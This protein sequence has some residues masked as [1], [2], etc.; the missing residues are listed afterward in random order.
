MKPSKL[1]AELSNIMETVTRHNEILT[2]LCGPIS[3]EPSP[4]IHD[5][6]ERIIAMEISLASFAKADA[7]KTIN[8][9]TARLDDYHH[10]MRQF[11]RRT[12][13]RLTELEDA[14]ALC[15]SHRID[16]HQHCSSGDLHAA[17]SATLSYLDS[18]HDTLTAQIAE[19]TARLDNLDAILT[20]TTEDPNHG[21]TKKTHT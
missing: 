18:L 17:H 3:T 1:Q 15:T 20:L 12:H 4:T 16:P 5:L 21:T 14:A 7:A 19:Q 8:Q 10:R 6:H 9:H 2:D 11:H 13:D